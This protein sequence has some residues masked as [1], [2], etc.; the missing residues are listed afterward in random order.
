MQGL[1]PGLFKQLHGLTYE[2]QVT[3]LDLAFLALLLMLH[4]F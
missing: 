4:L 1:A 2:V 3:L